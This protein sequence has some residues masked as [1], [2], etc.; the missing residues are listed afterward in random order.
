[1]IQSPSRTISFSAW[2]E[3]R[4][5]VSQTS[6]LVES[7]PEKDY[8]LYRFRDGQ[9]LASSV[10][11]GE[12]PDGLGKFLREAARFVDGNADRIHWESGGPALN[13]V[14]LERQ[15]IARRLRPE[16]PPH[17]WEKDITGILSFFSQT[18]QRR[19][20]Q[21]SPQLTVE[22][23]PQPRSTRTYGELGK[24]LLDEY[25]AFLRLCRDARTVI[26]VEGGLAITDINDDVPGTAA[27]GTVPSRLAHIQSRTME[28]RHVVVFNLNR[29]GSQEI[30]Q[31]GRAVFRQVNGM[32]RLLLVDDGLR[33]LGTAIRPIGSEEI[34]RNLIT[35]A[36]DLA[37]AGEGAL[38]VLCEDPT[39]EA[40][41]ELF[42]GDEG[43]VRDIPGTSLQELAARTRFTQLVATRSLRLKGP[44]THISPLLRDVCGIDGATVFTYEGEL[45][46]FG[47]LVR[48][49]LSPRWEA[50]AEGARTTAA[51]Q[52]SHKGVAIKV[53]S[54]GTASLYI[55]GREW[56]V[57]W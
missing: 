38:L 43:L 24:P 40:L 39:K 57:L 34:A 45:L 23:A 44:Y 53:S 49:Q 32:W 30:F 50:A 17:T 14:G 20:E 3:L 42:V 56:G 19:Y 21:S 47:C 28:K 12:L 54:D 25:R 13:G 35:L 22:Y 51:K 10:P 5:F 18:A 33:A 48:Q 9:C 37:D 52:A 55:G 1:M 4:Q 8:E 41:E 16:S 29:N 46:G 27:D 2:H 6:L 36:L 31:D 7:F 15:I 26:Q 11:V